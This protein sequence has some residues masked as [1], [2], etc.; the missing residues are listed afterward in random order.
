MKGEEP[1][2]SKKETTHRSEQAYSPPPKIQVPKRDKRTG[3]NPPPEPP[4][5]KPYIPPP[6]PAPKK[7]D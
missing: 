6:P 2:M 7:K 5:D 1:K 3:Y 4:P